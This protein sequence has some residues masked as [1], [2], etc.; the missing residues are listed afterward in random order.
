MLKK[1]IVLF[2][3]TI[4]LSSCINND[5]SNNMDNKKEEVNNN[6]LIELTDEDLKIVED[7]LQI[8]E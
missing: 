5:V 2:L 1:I 7:I 3:I 8:N 4:S 6:E